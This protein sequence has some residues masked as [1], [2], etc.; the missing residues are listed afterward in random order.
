MPLDHSTTISKIGVCYGGDIFYVPSVTENA[1]WWRNRHIYIQENYM[2]YDHLHDIF[3]SQK[4]GVDDMIFTVFRRKRFSI[5]DSD[6]PSVTEW[7]FYTYI[8]QCN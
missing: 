4:L 3:T 2:L 5:W 6:V 8:S 7:Q 1:V